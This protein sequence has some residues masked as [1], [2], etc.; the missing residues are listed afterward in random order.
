ML[1]ETWIDELGQ[2]N[3]IIHCPLGR[4]LNKTWAVGLT[5]YAR[6]ALKQNWNVTATNDLI[7]LTYSADKKNW[8]KP[9]TAE[10]LL[11]MPASK[12]ATVLETMQDSLS[13]GG[14]AFRETAACALQIRRA[15]KGRRVPMWL[16]NHRAQELYEVC[17]KKND[18]PVN[19]E[20]RRTYLEETL[21]IEGIKKFLGQLEKDEIKL[22][23]QTVESPSPFS[24]SLLIQDVYRSDHQMGRD[25]RA[26]LLRLHRKV[27]QE[28]LTSE[29]VAQ[30]LDMR[31]IE[32]LEKRL[33]CQSEMSNAKTVD[34]LTH[35][36]RTL[37]DI[38]ASIDAVS[39]IVEGDAVKLLE[40]LIKEYRVVAFA[41][42]DNESIPYHFISAE[43]WRQYHDA[44]SWK[45]REQL[46]VFIP[47]IKD[48]TIAGFTEV[49][50]AS[51]ISSKLLNKQ[52]TEIARKMPWARYSL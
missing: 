47:E 39:A 49:D 42:P 8:R 35:A 15:E 19:K 48:R 6:K 37:G 50:A 38:P 23:F 33:L 34:E 29:Q 21:N 52:P 18:Y 27:L 3:F 30:L 41:F 5:E 51:V 44:F 25:R 1:V 28:I 36:I 22:V 32:K 11:T 45:K 26:H 7:L 40:P 43:N 13:T 24:H 10:E 9:A 12:I 20:I 2:V 4:R 16:Q 17:G 31:A 46:K 14:S